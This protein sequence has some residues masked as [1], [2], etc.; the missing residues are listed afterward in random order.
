M[1]DAVGYAA[2]HSLSR[3]KRFEF[4]RG[5]ATDE[6]VS[7]VTKHKVSDLVGAGCMIDSC[8]QCAR[9]LAGGMNY[10][11]GPDSRLATCNGPMVSRAMARD[12]GNMYGKDNTFDGY[13]DVLVV[14]EVVP[15]DQVN[16]A[17]DKAEKGEVRFRC[18]IEMASLKPGLESR[19]GAR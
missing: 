3:F 19:A 4:Q 13:S 14:H 5:D 16:D 6:E 11:E 1:I 18:V 12:C 10:C 15:I 2:K 17:C 9:C 8:R 7:A